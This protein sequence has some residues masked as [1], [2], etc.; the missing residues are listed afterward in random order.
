MKIKTFLG[1]VA[2]VVV[3]VVILFPIFWMFK[4][5]FM[6]LGEANREPPVLFFQPTFENYVD[7]F[8]GRS[9]FPRY[10]L[11]SLIAAAGSSVVVLALGLPAA[12]SFAR[13]KFKGRTN[14]LYFI[15]SARML[16]PIAVVVPFYLIFRFIGLLDTP[17]AL[18]IVYTVM[19]MP[20]A[21]WLLKGFIEEVP[22]DLE[23]SA[24][25][26][27]CSRMGAFR[28]VIIPVLAPGLAVTT[29]FSF[30]F[31]WNELLFAVTLTASRA[32]TAPVMIAAFSTTVIEQITEMGATACV[33]ML[34]PIIFAFL[35]RKYF[36]AGLTLGAVKG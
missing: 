10:F 35:M 2:V 6:T 31:A 22:K 34:P 12:Y 36:V 27:G 32:A 25:V 9:P 20:L 11:N 19:N 18:I 30:V 16:P 17:F 26:D 7:S 5:S 24:M 23:E 14:A 33:Y 15:L 8:L 1:Y 3:M 13:F 28:R 29:I 21:V 4:L